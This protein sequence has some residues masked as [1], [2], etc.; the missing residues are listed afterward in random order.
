[1]T[2]DD[3]LAGM[4]ALDCAVDGCGGPAEVHHVTGAGMG[5]KAPFWA[6][7]PLCHPH[8]RTGGPGV[9]IH[10]G[11]GVP[12]WEARFGRQEDLSAFSRIR[13]AEAWGIPIGEL[14]KMIE[15]RLAA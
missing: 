1:M 2:E 13:L 5:L 11:L 10:D 9:S 14:W 3:F 7:I 12:D 4:A 15:V 8:H 6:V